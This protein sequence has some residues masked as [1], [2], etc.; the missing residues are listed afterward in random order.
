MRIIYIHQYF[1]TPEEGGSLR[2]FYIASD[3]VKK[4]HNVELITGHNGHKYEIKIIRGIR[5]HY[6]PVV[7]HNHFGSVRR[8][9]SFIRFAWLSIRTIRKLEV[10]DLLYIT[11]TP[12]TTGLA[13][14]YFQKKSQWPYVFEVRDL[15]PEAPIQ[16][17]YFRDPLSRYLVRNLEKRIYSHAEKIIGLSPGIV[18]HINRVSPEKKAH[19]IPNMSD[20]DFFRPGPK[21][22]DMEND[23]EI[24]FTIAYT[25]AVGPVNHLE[26]LLNAAKACQ[27]AR[28][29]VHFLVAGDG[30]R[31]KH[32][33]KQAEAQSLTNVEFLGHL[34]KEKIRTILNRS[35]AVYI[36]FK[37]IPVLE[38]NSPNKFFDGLAS[39]KI[40]IT[41][42]RGWLKDIIESEKCGFYANP[43]DPVQFSEKIRALLN[44]PATVAIYKKN[45]RN[46]AESRF[47]RKLITEKVSKVIELQDH[48]DQAN[49]ESVYTL[50]H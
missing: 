46:L 12:L 10:P 27:N 49:R 37:R 4:G 48:T 38:T 45:A 35:D 24:P 18:E 28:L 50:T 1:K 33:R 32:M 3:L 36:C 15:W 9:W 13:G 19:L 14:I 22:P 29:P 21:Q 42:I 8:I 25:G 47:S 16:M 23:R 20:C 17:G 30:A 34:N 31:L 39:G 2:S 40:C 26:Y 7:Y 41:N 6:L 44:D 5:V 11:S 43:D